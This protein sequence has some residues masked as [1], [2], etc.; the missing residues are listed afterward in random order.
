MKEKLL[1]DF[2]Q[3]SRSEWE[4]KI[5]ADLKGKPYEALLWKSEGI[6]G[7]PIYTQEDLDS[8]EQLTA[9]QNKGTSSHP[10]IYGSKHWT[11]Y[12]LVVVGNE[13]EANKTALAALNLG[14]E[15]LVFQITQP[16]DFNVLLNEIHLEHCAVSF[17]LTYSAPLFINGYLD[18][19]KK[20]DYQLNKVNG[21]VNAQDLIP[22]DSLKSLAEIPDFKGLN[23][24]LS[25]EFKGANVVQELAVLLHFAASKI[26]AFHQKGISYD[27]VFATTQYQ[28]NLGKN[29]FIEIAKVRA[30]RLLVQA[31]WKGF[32][33]E[34]NPSQV[35]IFSSSNDWD[36]P[37]ED[38]HNYMLEATTGAMSAILGGSNALLI[39]PFNTTFETQPA[40]AVRNARNISSILKEESYL[41]KVTDPSAGSFYVESITNQLIEKVWSLFLKLEKTT[42]KE[43]INMSALNNLTSENN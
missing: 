27:T 18:Y 6:E 35:M 12:Q 43:V 32:D 21:F 41:D 24:K 22:Q 33:I 36:H 20:E 37:A 31:L 11:N 4:Q 29:Y 19:I 5:I 3:V 2:N 39:R 9:V 7:S 34:I 16:V 23:I 26:V 17:D 40:L 13:L 42:D 1:D 15:G 28:L 8:I 30:L 25:D 14:A 38:K 10:E